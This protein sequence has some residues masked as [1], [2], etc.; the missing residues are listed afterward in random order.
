MSPGGH[1]EFAF[2]EWVEYELLRRGWTRGPRGYDPELGL[3]TPELWEFVGKTQVKRF[4][5]LIELYGGDQSAA[6][7]AFAIRVANEI[8]ARGVLDV[9]RHGV[10]DRG[11]LV[12]LCYFRPGHTLAANALKEYDANVL[13]VAR[14]LHFSAR[15]AKQSVDLAFFVN[16]LPVA[17]VE[18]KNRMTGQDAENDAVAQ[19][20]RREPNE[21]FFAKRTLVH[22][23]VDPDR[24]LVTT[25]LS[26]GDTEFLPFNVGS[27]G[28]GNS[29]GAGN[30]GPVRND[31]YCVS[32]LWEHIW[33][34]D[35]WLEI[36]QRYLH[37]QTAGPKDNPHTAPRI[38]PRYHQW[39]AVQRMVAD[40]RNRGAGQDYLIEHSAGSG[41]S[42]TIAWLAHRLSTLFSDVNEQVFHKVIVI[43]DRTVL[44]KQLQRTIYQFDHTPGVVTRIDEDSAQLAAAL[45]DSTSKIIISTLQKFPYVLDKIAGTELGGKRYAIIVDEAHSSQGGNAA[46]W[47]RQAIGADNEQRTDETSLEYLGRMRRKQPNLS[48]FAFTATPTA[49][50]LNLFGRFD[51]TRLNPHRPGESGMNVPFHVYSMRQAI[52]ERY[53]LDVLAS[54]ITYDLKWRL[55]NMAVEQQESASANPEVDERKAKRELVRFAVRHPTSVDQR[56]KLIV[57]DF[58]DNVASR[59]GGRAKAMV[60]T[61]SRADAL[62]TYQAMQTYADALGFGTLVAFSGSL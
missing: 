50:T 42:N 15:A 43:T 16:G 47:L 33:E 48:Y 11:L 19:Y 54:Y 28:A 62:T 46:A 27:A 57:D 38:F 34:R 29:G 26:G 4:E 45:E 21:L 56:A 17:S 20:R 59:L 7:R 24:A 31:D 22:F 55:R 8:D 35:N 18:L 5:K 53:I 36:L 9:L 1:T 14:Q 12:D 25:R 23:A 49:R 51:P 44:D 32:Y 58:R 3:A 41:K 40:A 61:S 37:V 30:P 52:E 39:D 2:E 6:M 60:V 13:S 10:K